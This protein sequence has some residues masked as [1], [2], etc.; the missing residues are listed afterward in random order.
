MPNQNLEIDLAA[1]DLMKGCCMQHSPSMSEPYYPTVRLELTEKVDLPDGG[2]VT[3]RFEKTESSQRSTPEGKVY[4]CTL[5]LTE[6]CGVEAEKVKE[7]DDM[8]L[9]ADEALDK[10]AKEKADEYEDEED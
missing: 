3:F 1:P 2:T 7:K 8:D 5:K 4:A 10:L 6:L 9:R